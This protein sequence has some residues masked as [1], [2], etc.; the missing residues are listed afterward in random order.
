MGYTNVLDQAPMT[1]QVAP[2][3]PP[4]V[5]ALQ[6]A[7]LAVDT[8]WADIENNVEYVAPASWYARP[9]FSSATTAAPATPTEMPPLPPE[10]AEAAPA[11]ILYTEDMRQ[12]LPGALQGD[13][14]PPQ[15]GELATEVEKDYPDVRMSKSSRPI[16]EDRR[17]EKFCLLCHQVRNQRSGISAHIAEY[18]IL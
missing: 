2:L 3:S 9:S 8:A 11:L 4:P 13:E 12:T 15:S 16:P 5:R 14:E 1:P 17:V 10:T 18:R 7:A 6:D